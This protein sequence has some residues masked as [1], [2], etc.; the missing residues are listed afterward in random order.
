MRVGEGMK[1]K[2]RVRRRGVAGH[3]HLATGWLAP[4]L[5]GNAKFKELPESYGNNQ[6]EGPTLDTRGTQYFYMTLLF[7]KQKDVGD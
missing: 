7:Q 1:G 5:L 3:R 4:P 6:T 2:G